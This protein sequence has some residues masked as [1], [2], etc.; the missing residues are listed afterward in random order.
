LIE[1]KEAQMKKCIAGGWNRREKERMAKKINSID[2]KGLEQYHAGASLVV[3]LENFKAE[4]FSCMDLWSIPVYGEAYHMYSKGGRV[5]FLFSN[6]YKSRQDLKKWFLQIAGLLEN[7]TVVLPKD[8][9]KKRFSLQEKRQMGLWILQMAKIG[10]SIKEKIF[11][12]NLL[13]TGKRNLENIVGILDRVRVCSIVTLADVHLSDYMVTAYCN[14]R[15]IRTVT[16]QH[17]F[18]P[19][20]DMFFR[21][22]ESD[23]FLTYSKYTRQLAETYK[24]RR[25]VFVEVGMP[26]CVSLSISSVKR[27]RKCGRFLV[28]LNGAQGKEQRA[29][30]KMLRI[31][32]EYAQKNQ[33]PFD[34]KAHPGTESLQEYRA[35]MSHWGRFITSS[36]S[37]EELFEQYDF[38]VANVTTMVLK[39]VYMMT[40]IV[41]LKEKNEKSFFGLDKSNFHF[42]NFEEMERAVCYLKEKS[43]EKELLKIREFLCGSGDISQNYKEFFQKL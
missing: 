25:G 30:K 9:E 39:A 36:E 14:S 35:I 32:R 22:S 10:L 4:K 19:E 2:F 7:K 31:C 40:P 16:L 21:Y 6:S 8:E 5:M 41:L 29:N 37:A 38:C 1:E 3:L 42:S 24:K 11:C 28:L 17:G 23:Y 20:D 15:G 43:A 26:D 18:F 12:A 34:V 13:L 27:D 33:C